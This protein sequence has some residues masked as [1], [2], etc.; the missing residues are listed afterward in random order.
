MKTKAGMHRHIPTNEY[1]D[2]RIRLIDG[3]EV[4]S[5]TT[6]T[7]MGNYRIYHVAGERFADIIQ[8]YLS[9]DMLTN[10]FFMNSP[11]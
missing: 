11:T 5:V 9:K 6:D 8:H 1:G 3:V 2:L 4:F 10:D 7:I